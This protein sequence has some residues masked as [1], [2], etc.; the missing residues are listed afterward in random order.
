MKYSIILPVYNEEENVE[1]VYERVSAVLKKITSEFELIY[2]NDGSYDRTLAVLKDLHKRDSRVKVISF[3]RNFGH[4]TGVSVGLLKSSGKIVAVLDGDLQ[5]PP[6]V[7][8][9]FFD[10]LDEGYDVVYA[11]RTKRKEFFLK[12]LAYD[13]FY[14]LLQSISQIKIPLDSGD[15]CVMNR[16][17]VDA[18]NSLPERNRY[19]RGL[20][21]WVGFKQIGITYDRPS[22]EAGETKYTLAKLFKLAFDGIFSFSYVP[23]QMM[24]VGGFIALNLS[25]LYTVW[26]IYQKYFTD[27]YNQVPGFAT[28]VILITFFGGLQLFSLGIMGEYMRRMYDETKQRPQAIIESLIGF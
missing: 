22:R 3:S 19:V 24:S 17:V 11:V 26:V 7:L 8:P 16:R 2:I 20:R 6:E 25:A 28:N 5:D 18:M 15:F 10:K 1:M 12:R 14:R 21:S 4:Q 23:L 13:S 27:N 9:T